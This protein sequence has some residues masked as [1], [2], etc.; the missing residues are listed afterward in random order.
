MT[1]RI[2][3]DWTV[4]GVWWDRDNLDTGKLDAFKAHYVY[5]DSHT[6]DA[7]SKC[8]AIR[9]IA[10]TP[11]L[12]FD[13]HWVGLLDPKIQ[14]KRCYD[15]AM[16][17]LHPGEPIMLD[18]E[19]LTLAWTTAFIRAIRQHMPYRPISL[20][21]GPGQDTSVIPASYMKHLGLHAYIQL[22]DDKMNDAPAKQVWPA[23][24]DLEIHGLPV[25]MIHPVYEGAGVPWDATDGC[26]FTLS[27]LP[28]QKG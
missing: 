9:D 16:A 6:P 23:K 28:R 11:G 17:C 13:P 15:E 27:D 21:F 19:Q 7:A 1:L 4:M 10:R 14:A 26:I 18:V 5:V 3:I 20:T 22:Y 24:R 25:E 2:D 8:S 12:Y